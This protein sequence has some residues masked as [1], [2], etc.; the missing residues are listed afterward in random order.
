[1][2]ARLGQSAKFVT[3]S[4]PT[5][6]VTVPAV[7]RSLHTMLGLLVCYRDKSNF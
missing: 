3:L 7:R 2:D 4:S 6:V 5:T 1:M